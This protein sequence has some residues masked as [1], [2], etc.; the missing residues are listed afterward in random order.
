VAD[1]PLYPVSRVHLDALGGEFGIW[2]HALGPNPV[3]AFGYC[4]DDVARALTVDLLHSRQ[5]GW[6]AVRSSAWRSLRFL[7]DA[8][9]PASGRFRN[10]RAA[11]G[12]WLGAV[13]SDDSQG[14]A[15]LAL[16]GAIADAPEDEAIA[17]A[18]DLFRAA[19]PA[20]TALSSPRALASSA[21]G[22]VAALTAD[23]GR[24]GNAGEVA[25]STLDELASTLRRSFVGLTLQ[26]DWPWPEAVLTYENALLPRAVMSAGIVLGDREMVRMGLRVLDWL[27][28]VQTV[29]EG[30]FSPIGNENWWPRGGF[31]SRFD[32]QPIEATSMIL[33]AESAFLYTGKTRYLRAMESAYGWFL[34]DNDV[35]AQLADPARGSCK[36]GLS[37]L[38]ASD[39]EGAESTLMWLTALE[40]VR[41]T[42]AAVAA[43]V[44]ATAG[45]TA[46]GLTTAGPSTDDESSAAGGGRW[47]RTPVEARR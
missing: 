23:P 4:T 7:G 36:D 34:G 40:H 42:R 43:A 12:T 41:G 45:P 47:L 30:T 38:C 6:D 32:Q 9:D 14:R 2:Q 46:A 8:F 37:P 17:R 27:I 28:R 33:A 18:R 25:Q 5:L 31:R 1:R 29:A 44:V 26:R 39:N 20:S 21:L 24:I 15:L 22:C 3:G 13:G 16:S 35:G 11:D 19:L 10:F